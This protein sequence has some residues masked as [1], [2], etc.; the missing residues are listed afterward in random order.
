[1]GQLLETYFAEDGDEGLAG[2][3]MYS[4]TTVSVAVHVTETSSCTCNG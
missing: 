4:I 1:M 2:E 3:V